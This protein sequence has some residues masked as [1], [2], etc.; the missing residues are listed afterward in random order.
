MYIADHFAMAPT[1][2]ERFVKTLRTGTLVTVDPAT[3]LP[4]ATFLPW[5]FQADPDRLTS[6]VARVNPQWRHQ[7][8]ALITAVFHHSVVPAQWKESFAIGQSAPG[9]DYE[10]LNIRGELRA[11][12]QPDDVMESWRAMLEQHRSGLDLS[13]LDADWLLR[14]ARATVA[15]SLRVESV[16]AKS[17]LSQN[18]SLADIDAISAGLDQTCPA[19]AERM[20]QVSRPWAERRQA[21][22]DQARRQ[23]EGR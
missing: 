19:L 14:Q 15:L 20:R 10:A 6:H 22:V 5:A 4:Q 12:D 7:G 17:K 23:A 1:D 9:L 3:G 18:R 11:S 8:P 2:T 16:E 13:H 21:A